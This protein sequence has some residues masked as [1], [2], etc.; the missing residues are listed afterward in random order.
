MSMHFFDIGVYRKKPS[1]AV[2]DWH[3]R[4]QRAVAYPGSNR[5]E[6]NG[7]L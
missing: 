5:T 1:A 3:G 7:T 6:R 4:P 2:V